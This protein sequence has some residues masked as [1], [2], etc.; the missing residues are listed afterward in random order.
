MGEPARHTLRL[1]SPPGDVNAVHDL[2]DCVWADVTG[3]SMRDRVSFETA[4]I[5]LASNIIGHADT[6]SGV[7]CTLT[8]EITDDRMEATLRD[9]GEC[10]N[11]DL[12]QRS[13]PDELAES[14]R[15]LALIQALVDDLDYSQ[16]GN[17]NRWHITRKRES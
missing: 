8:I 11:I 1:E 10:G 4:L 14:G 3:L 2:L 6:G 16:E 15:G 5:E 12:R 9:T 7:T 13:M 17:L